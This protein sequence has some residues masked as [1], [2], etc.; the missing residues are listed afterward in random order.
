HQVVS[1]PLRVTEHAP[2]R[3]VLVRHEEYHGLPRGNVVKVECT[4]SAVDD[5]YPAFR[6]GELDLVRVVYT[7]HTADH[8]HSQVGGGE[9][10]TWLAYI[11]CAHPHAQLQDVELRRA[12]ALAIDRSALAEAAPANLAAATGGIVPPA[13]YGHSPDIA[14]KLDLERARAHL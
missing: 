3:L 5:A 2:E 6:R 4:R 12:L 9:P 8:V 10:L 13:L 7:P 14:P 11:G 1:G